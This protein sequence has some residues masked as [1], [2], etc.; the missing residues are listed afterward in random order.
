L[1]WLL[2]ARRKK[3]LRPHLLPLLQHLLLKLPHQ[4]L[5]RPHL[6]PLL[7]LLTPLPLPLRALLQALPSNSS[8]N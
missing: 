8:V 4:P 3:L 5:P 2:A 6:L 7:R 1:L